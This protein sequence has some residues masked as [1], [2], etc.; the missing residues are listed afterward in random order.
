MTGATFG[1]SGLSHIQREVAC[2][3]CAHC[4]RSRAFRRNSNADVRSSVVAAA[5]MSAAGGRERSVRFGLPASRS[6]R[7]MALDEIGDSRSMGLGEIVI[8]A[9]TDMKVGVRKK[10]Q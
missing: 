8:S 1:S 5:Q 10:G 7:E 9:A 6:G 4:G 2:P 3:S